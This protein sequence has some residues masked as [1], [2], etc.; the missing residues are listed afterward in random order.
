M[1]PA[2]VNCVQNL[3]KRPMSHEDKLLIKEKGRPIPDLRINYTST[4][5]SSS[6]SK[7]EEP[8]NLDSS[9]S[10]SEVEEPYVN[11]PVQNELGNCKGNSCHFLKNWSL[12][13]NISH[14]AIN[15]L[16]TSVVFN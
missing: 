7:V 9:S 10:D 3:F 15:E 4:D 14:N 13:N 12:K 1:E 8:Y 2:E 6:D 16:G 5:S 11:L